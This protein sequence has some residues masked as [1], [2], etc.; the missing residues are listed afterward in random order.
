MKEKMKQASR[1]DVKARKNMLMSMADNMMQLAD[2]LKE[3]GDPLDSKDK[4]LLRIATMPAF[5]EHVSELKWSFLE[6]DIK[7]MEHT[8]EQLFQLAD[9]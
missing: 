3:S 5:S 6:G 1:I 4:E 9:F 8:F 7:R 2:R